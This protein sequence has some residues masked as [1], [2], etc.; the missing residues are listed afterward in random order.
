MGVFTQ[1]SRRDEGF[2]MKVKTSITLSEDLVRQIDELSGQYGNR[3]SLIERAIRNFLAAQA[4]RRRDAQD[5]EILNR[6]A[7]A[8][9]REAGD[10]LS[11]Q[12]DV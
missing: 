3:S 4:K 5:T 7:D 6:C 8:L 9:N 1:L 11:Y 12:V 10:V 2:I